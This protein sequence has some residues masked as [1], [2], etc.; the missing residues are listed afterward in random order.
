MLSVGS[1]KKFDKDNHAVS[2]A[3][4]TVIMTAA[5]VVLVLVATSYANS[6]LNYQ[7]G[8]DEF[9]SNQ[10]FMRST[11]QQI[12]DVAWTIG[13]TETVEFTAK[14]AQVTVVPNAI[15]YTFET[16]NGSS[17]QTI[18]NST[19]GIILFNMPVASYSLGNDYFKRLV[20][21]NSGSFIQWNSS[22]VTSQVFTTQ[23]VPMK[24]G[25]YAR[26]VTVPTVRVMNST[27]ITGGN[28][29][30]FYLPSLVSGSNAYL[31]QSLT[32]TGNGINKVSPSSTFS[33]IRIN[34]TATAASS[35]PPGF[36]AAFFNFDH[37][38]E[39]LTIPSGS[40][41]E[42]YFGTVNVSIGMVG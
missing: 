29:Y 24:D 37:T 35:I 19:T 16:Y 13:R 6:I 7:L 10:Q 41:V 4:S 27:L 18:Y 9:S 32:F 28:Y 14:Y 5:I 11:G 20:P 2:P 25:S 17:W 40:L 15:S 12:D 33:L 42:F 26:I 34:A 8:L 23:K 38:T 39:T 3:I 31:S 30:K 21:A 22:A 36:D 1:R